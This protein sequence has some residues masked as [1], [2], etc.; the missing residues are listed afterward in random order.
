MKKLTLLMSCVLIYTASMAQLINST[1]TIFSEDGHKFYLILNGTRM[2]DK[3]ETNIRLQNLTQPYYNCKILFDDKALGE[4][5]KNY[6]P[7]T[8][9]G[10]Q[11]QSMDVTYKIKT[12]K[13]GKQV[14]RYFSATPVVVTAT[15]VIPPDVVVYNYGTTIPVVQTTVTETTTTTTGTNA[16]NVGV[17]MGGM[18]VNMNVHINDPNLS[19]QQT[20]T[21]TTYTTTT[22]TGSTPPPPPPAAAGPC[23]YAMTSADY[24]SAKASIEK[25]T[26]EETKLK[27]AK[28]IISNNCMYADQI[29]SICRLFTF[30]ASKLD[31]AKF[32]YKYCY[33]K[34]NYFKIN[35]VFEFDA[36]RDELSTFTAQ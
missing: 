36:S 19:T 18:G 22:T 3:P 7:V 31:F 10:N 32:A 25:A 30:E 33:D 9:P 20:T 34:N 16:A 35:D 17:N 29:R 15:P 11:T 8:D 21:T 1:L 12:D 4:V 24:A 28:S 6:L 2:N 14:L 26:F 23:A 5:S 13:N 27:S